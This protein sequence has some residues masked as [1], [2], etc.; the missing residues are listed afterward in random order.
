MDAIACKCCNARAILL[1][2][3]DFNKTCMDQRL[4][5]LVFPSANRPIPYWGC[6]NCGFVFTQ[7]MDNWSAD[8]F[9]REIYN[10]DWYKCDIPP[11]GEGYDIDRNHPS[12]KTGLRYAQ[13]LEKSR[14]DIR[15]LDYGSGGNPGAV[16]VALL[17]SGYTVH[18]YEPYLS[19]KTSNTP[20]GKYDVITMLEVIEH[21]HNL[22]EVICFMRTRLC[23]DG[24]LAISTLLHPHP[25]NQTV[26]NSW[27]IAPRNGH[28]SIFTLPALT[29]LFHR[30]GIKII[31]TAK[32]LFGLYNFPLWENSVM[33]W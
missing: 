18:S 16:A 5:K 3:I 12:Y 31:H 6:T 15:I 33:F 21:C 19:D 24:I 32:G 2:S 26:L 30:V 29:L 25:T 9:R 4:G 10:K 8:E 17:E 11:P 7:Y 22:E 13:L 23:R 20:D 1:G 27:Y 14:D 28:V